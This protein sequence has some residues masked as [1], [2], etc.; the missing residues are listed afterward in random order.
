M[1]R[2]YEQN[3]IDVGLEPQSLASATKTGSY[4]NMKEFRSALAILT[5]GNI[6]AAG[7]VALQ[8]MQ[9]K[10]ADAGSAA[11]ITGALATILANVYAKKMKITCA[12]GVSTD[13]LTLTVNGVAYIFTAF[14]AEDLSIS[15]WKG[16]GDD[17]TDATSIVACINTTL[18]GK[19][20]AENTAG[21]I[22]LTAYDGYL[23]DAVAESGAFTTI[24]TLA[25]N[26]YVWIEGLDLTALFTHIACK[27]TTAGNT[28]ICS[29]VL[30]RG[31]SRKG[32]TQ[33]VG[34]NYPA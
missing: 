6:T 33:K 28:G 16:D 34:D 29:A 4:F 21:V 23:I 14:T 18:A 22:T 11:V 30:I 20:F 2:N 3:K 9:A 17:E 27:V 32:I 25:A 31:K 26:A 1:Q 8:V 19:I 15:Q 10:D 5:V 12:G 13:T 7:S 24:L